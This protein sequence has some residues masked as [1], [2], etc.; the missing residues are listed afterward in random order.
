M[1]QI[2]KLHIKGQ[3]SRSHHQNLG[4]LISNFNFTTK[5]VHILQ[6]SWLF[7]KG[8]ESAKKVGHSPLG[9]GKI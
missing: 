6:I 8:Q 1:I 5:I 3:E 4:H 9:Q 2:S 7:I